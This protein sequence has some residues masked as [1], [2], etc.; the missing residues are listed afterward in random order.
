MRSAPCSDVVSVI[1]RVALVLACF[2]PG[3]SHLGVSEMARRANLPKSTVSRLVSELV[4]HRYLERDDEGVRLGVRLFELGELA[5]LPN[6]L[7]ANAVETMADLRDAVGETV[8]L[9]VLDGRDVLCLGVLHARGGARSGPR[10]GSRSPA[11]LSAVGRVLLAWSATDTAA[12]LVTAEGIDP[13]DAG[14][15]A[16]ELVAIRERGVAFDIEL[17]TGR[18]VGVAAAVSDPSTAS[19]AAIA[20]TGDADTFDPWRISLAVQDAA[21]GI[22]RRAS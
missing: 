19:V 20:V 7:R 3:D 1:D 17:Q 18:I 10:V 5:T 14:E 15:L 4:L 8:Q 9:A 2:L 22:E 21:I 6:T 13:R 16:D 12:A 11:H